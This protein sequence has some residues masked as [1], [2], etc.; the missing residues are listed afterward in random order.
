[1][2]AGG[3]PCQAFSYAGKRLGFEDIRG[4]LFFEYARAIEQIKPKIILAENVKGLEKHDEGRTLSTMIHVLSQLGYRIAYKVL[5]AQY[6][7]VAQ[8]RERLVIIGVRNDLSCSII[9]PK[10]Q[11]YTISIAEVLK[12]VP[13]SD[14]QTY[15]AQKKKIMEL[16][17]EGG[18]WRN[19]PD[20]LQRDYMGASYHLSGGKTGM[21]RRLSWNEPSLTLTCNPAQK[22]TERCHPSQTRPLTIREYARI[23][24]FPDS[25]K[26]VG[27][28]SS[29]YKQIGNA[30]PVNLAYHIG[31]CLV[32]MLEN[33]FDPLSMTILP[34][35]QI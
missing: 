16:I 7:D 3:F 21:A 10:E 4:S 15:T 20:V 24:S 33:Y 27:S 17:P 14:G 1:M 18:Y 28:R 22:Q 5:R 31:R 8:K 35:T 19:L 25:W 30:V 12:D 6:L 34:E 23:Q 32:A 29:Q 9:F 2:L 11:D 26:F 13:I